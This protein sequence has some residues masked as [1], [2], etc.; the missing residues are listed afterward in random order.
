M[1]QSEMTD[2]IVAS[3]IF[4]TRP[5]KTAPSMTRSAENLTRMWIILF[6]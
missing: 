3:N 6:G 1:I 4:H 5:H 2:Q